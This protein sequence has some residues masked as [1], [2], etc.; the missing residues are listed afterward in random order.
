M[1]KVDVFFFGIFFYGIFECDYI[2]SCGKV[3]YGVFKYIF[4][5]GKVGFG[6]VMVYYDLKI[7]IKFLC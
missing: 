1:E 5:E 2:M 6:K 4:D 3:Y 7:R